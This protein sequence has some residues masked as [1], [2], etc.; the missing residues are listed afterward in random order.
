MKIPA[1][2]ATLTQLWD[3]AF[4]GYLCMLTEGVA[5][6]EGNKLGKFNPSSVYEI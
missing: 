2:M 3:P 5:N 4:T 1:N 6:L